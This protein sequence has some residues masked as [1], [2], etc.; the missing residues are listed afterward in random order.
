MADPVE[1]YSLDK[2]VRGLSQLAQTFDNREMYSDEQRRGAMNTARQIAK[3]ARSGDSSLYDVLGDASFQ[4]PDVLFS[5]LES[6]QM[7][8]PTSK[9]VREGMYQDKSLTE[10][11]AAMKAAADALMSRED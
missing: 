3:S 6:M 1:M 2:A 11:D 9:F 10:E 5:S 4:S 8:L 7:D